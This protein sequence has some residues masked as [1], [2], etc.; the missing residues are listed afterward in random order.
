MLPTVDVRV[1]VYCRGYVSHTCAEEITL[2][3]AYQLALIMRQM[4][5]SQDMASCGR[6]QKDQAFGKILPQ[7]SVFG[8]WS[9]NKLTYESDSPFIMTPTILAD[10]AFQLTNFAWGF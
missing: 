3:E 9:D 7:A 10:M 8:Q 6:S 5:K 4:S 1:S 2:E